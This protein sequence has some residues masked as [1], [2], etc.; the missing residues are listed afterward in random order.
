MGSEAFPRWSESDEQ[1][2]VAFVEGEDGLAV[3]AEEHQVSLPVSRCLPV[4]SS[5]GTFCN[6][7]SE[8]DE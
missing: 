4:I 6:R 1:S 2:G 8:V 7:A 5:L 3:G